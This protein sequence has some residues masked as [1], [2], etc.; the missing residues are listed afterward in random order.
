MEWGQIICQRYSKQQPASLNDMNDEYFTGYL[1]KWSSKCLLSKSCF[2][3]LIIIFILS[4]DDMEKLFTKFVR[5]QQ[6][7]GTCSLGAAV[8]ARGHLCASRLSA[9]LIKSR[10]SASG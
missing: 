7:E 2:V 4:K 3:Y 1:K 5:H 9:I 8:W 6:S 10:R